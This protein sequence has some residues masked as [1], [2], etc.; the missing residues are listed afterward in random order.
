MCPSRF[1]DARPRPLG[2]AEEPC[3]CRRF[4]SDF[5]F[6][7]FLFFVIAVLKAGFAAPSTGRLPASRQHGPPGIGA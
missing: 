6:P 2:T 1:K 5:S 4:A 3:V 7:F